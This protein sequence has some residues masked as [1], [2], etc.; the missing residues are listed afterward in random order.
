MPASVLG[1]FR[2]FLGIFQHFFRPFSGLQTPWGTMLSS[3]QQR[4]GGQ[5][6]HIAPGGAM[7]RL[8]DQFVQLPV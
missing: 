6:L 2:I 3:Q 1:A 4:H 7:A 5:P 8:D